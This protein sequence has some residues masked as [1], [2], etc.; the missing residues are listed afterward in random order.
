MGTLANIAKVAATEFESNGRVDGLGS[1]SKWT[2]S[3]RVHVPELGTVE[4]LRQISGDSYTL[5]KSRRYKLRDMAL[6][7]NQQ[8]IA[9][10]EPLSL[11]KKGPGQVPVCR[12]RAEGELGIGLESLVT[13][14]GRGRAGTLMELHGSVGYFKLGVRSVL[15]RCLGYLASNL[16]HT[17]P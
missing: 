2:S 9:P 14:S 3:A 13:P 12:Q 11:P 6:R 7:A 5:I 17:C 10:H 1:E 15:H 8:V 16:G 4:A